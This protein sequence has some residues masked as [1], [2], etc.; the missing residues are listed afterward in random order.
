ME[1]DENGSHKRAKL[2]QDDKI[3]SEVISDDL[4]KVALVPTKSVIRPSFQF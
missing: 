4:K 2:F 3:L 1:I